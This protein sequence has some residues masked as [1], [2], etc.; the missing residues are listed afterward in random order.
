[1][2]I[3]YIT[4]KDLR[5]ALPSPLVLAFMLVL[6]LLQAGLPY[7]AFHGF[8]QGLNVQ[9]TRLVVANLDQPVAEYPDFQ[10]GILLTTMLHDDG[11]RNLLEVSDVDSEFA[12]RLAVDERTADVAV[13]I[14]ADF[15]AAL[16]R[17]SGRVTVTIIHNPALM[18]GPA[19]VR[20][21]VN[22]FMDGFAGAL[23]A[24]DVA[25]ARITGMDEAVRLGVMQGYGDWAQTIGISLSQGVHPGIRYEASPRVEES[26]PVMVALIGPIMLGMLVFFAFFVGAISAQSILRED[27]QG[28]LARLY[29]TPTSRFA[30]LS[31]KFLAVAF[32]LILQVGLLLAIGSALFGISWGH[33]IPVVCNGLGLV[34][35]AGGFGVML[36]AFMRSTRQAFLIMGGAVILSGMAGGTMTTSFANLPA[37]FEIVNLLTPQ[38]WVLR[39]FFAAMRGG[40]LEALAPALVSALIGLICLAAGIYKLNRRFE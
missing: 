18:L 9:V 35:A 36:M 26:Q 15:S 4:L 7:L 6:P 11:L 20:D 5:R 25:S 10:A 17:T 39:G 12:A 27:E 30:I 19:I 23:M 8:S 24:A 33:W 13:V 1:M 16:F 14:P 2:K 31:G 3:L 32:I 28:T 40:M 34:M 37:A 22:N 38:G 29:K 21:V